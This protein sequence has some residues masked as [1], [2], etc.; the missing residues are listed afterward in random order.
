MRK[1]KQ[2]CGVYAY[3]E[4]TG[5]LQNGS[6]NDIAEAKKAYWATVRKE[7]KKNRRSQC[8]SVTVFFDTAEL[9]KV[10]HAAKHISVTSY[11]KQAALLVSNKKVSIDKIAVGEIRE[12][13]IMLY[14]AI[15]DLMEEDKISKDDGTQ[16]LKKLTIIEVK[17]MKQLQQV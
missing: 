6:E 8:K 14:S 3:L 1:R 11:V 7:W 15:Q 16:L 13:I 9:K 5:I 10:L 17:T 12:L 2:N 4:S